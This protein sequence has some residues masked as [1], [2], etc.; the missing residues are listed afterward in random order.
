MEQAICFAFRP[1]TVCCRRKKGLELFRTEQPRLLLKGTYIVLCPCPQSTNVK[2]WS[3]LRKRRI[4]QMKANRLILWAVVCE[5]G[6][7]RATKHGRQP[8]RYVNKSPIGC[9]GTKSNIYEK[10]ICNIHIGNTHDSGLCTVTEP[11]AGICRTGSG[12]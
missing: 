6:Y 5:L 9:Q 3:S 10:V 8:T 4:A 2:K 1:E 12:S 11:G 7:R